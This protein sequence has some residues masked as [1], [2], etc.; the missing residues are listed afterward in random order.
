M[1]TQFNLFGDT[2]DTSGDT[3]GASN[4]NSAGAAYEN[5]NTGSKRLLALSEFYDGE[6]RYFP[7]WLTQTQ[8]DE[9]FTA[10][11][12]QLAWRQDRIKLYGKWV[13]IPRMQAWYGDKEAAYCYSG[14][15]MEPL[16][17]LKPLWQMKVACEKNCGT[18]QI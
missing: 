5:N 11:K 15:E 16:P 6:L 12:E 17:W 13:P 1:T 18:L 4:D 3:V 9:L 7:D 8:A 2:T 10:L 14:V